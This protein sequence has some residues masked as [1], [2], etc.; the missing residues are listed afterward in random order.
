MVYLLFMLLRVVSDYE[1]M[2][3]IAGTEGE[4]AGLQNLS[5]PR[6]SWFR[7]QIRSHNVNMWP[8]MYV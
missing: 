5:L 3:R 8:C 2:Y 7:E 1:N 6:R 4:I